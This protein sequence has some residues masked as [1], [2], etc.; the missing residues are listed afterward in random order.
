MLVVVL[1]QEAALGAGVPTLLALRVASGVV[2]VLGLAREQVLAMLLAP[3]PLLGLG[4]EA[5]FARSSGCGGS[6]WAR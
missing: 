1:L 6:S 5:R 3:V 2:P 4:A